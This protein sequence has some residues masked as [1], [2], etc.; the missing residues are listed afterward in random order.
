M[1]SQE[2]REHRHEVLVQLL[3]LFQDVVIGVV[4]NRTVQID[5]LRIVRAR[6]EKCVVRR[7]LDKSH[8]SRPTQHALRVR[9]EMIEISRK[10]RLYCAVMEEFTKLLVPGTGVNA[11]R[12]K[13][14]KKIFSVLARL[15]EILDCSVVVIGETALK[16]KP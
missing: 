10:N 5:Y 1:V 15:E 2:R 7:S 14:Q 12:D 9:Q 16:L 11:R 13:F 4:F 6:G 3:D 8:V